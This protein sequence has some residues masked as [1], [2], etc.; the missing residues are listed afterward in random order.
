MFRNWKMRQIEQSNLN[1]VQ[2]NNKVNTMFQN[3]ES[4]NFTMM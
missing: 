3:F 2:L 4:D 1:L